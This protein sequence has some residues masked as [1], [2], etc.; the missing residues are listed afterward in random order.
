MEDVWVFWT[1]DRINSL[2]SRADRATDSSC[3]TTTTSSTSSKE[4]ESPL[5]AST[6]NTS[7]SSSVSPAIARHLSSAATAANTSSTGFEEEEVPQDLGLNHFVH[8]S[9]NHDVEFQS[10]ICG[11]CFSAQ[12]AEPLVLGNGE[13]TSHNSIRSGLNSIINI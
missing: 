11:S 9:E 7:S 13:F 4:K 8:S 10:N 1:Q 12:D 6:R 2:Q 3:S 5:S